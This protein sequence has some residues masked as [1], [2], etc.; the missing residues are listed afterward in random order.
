LIGLFD[1]K[2]LIADLPSTNL[3]L[4]FLIGSNAGSLLGFDFFANSA[5]CKTLSIFPD[6]F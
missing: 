3:I 4:L 5:F 6:L 2:P 1:S